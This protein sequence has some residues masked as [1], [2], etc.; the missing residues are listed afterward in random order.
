MPRSFHVNPQNVFTNHHAFSHRK[1]AKR[2]YVA[3]PLIAL[4]VSMSPA[5]MGANGTWNQ[6]AGGNWEL[7]TTGP[8]LGGVVANGSGAI[9][10]FTTQDITGDQTITLTTDAISVGQLKFQDATT[11]TNN[12]ILASNAPPLTLDNGA[13]QPIINILNQTTTIT[14]ALAGTNGVNLTGG[15]ATLVLNSNTYTRSSGFTT[16]INSTGGN[17]FNIVANANTAFGTGSIDVAS[18]TRYRILLNSGVTINNN[19]QLDSI[20]ST[21]GGNGALQTNGDVTATLTGTIT[22]NGSNTAGGGVVG[23]QEGTYSRTGNFLIFTGAL[24]AGA[25]ISGTQAKTVTGG[26]GNKPIVFR[27]GNVQLSGGGNLYRIEQ[28]AGAIQLGATNGAPTTAYIDLGGNSNGNPQNY[29]ILDLN[30]FN[31][32]LTGVTNFVNNGQSATVT[33]SSTTST[34]TLTLT[35]AAQSVGD[36]RDLV[37]TAGANGTGTNASLTDSSPA[38]PLNLTVN[39]AADGVQYMTTSASSYRGVT[40]LTSG[41]LAVSS[42]ANGGV[43]SSIGASSNAA[44]NLM[45]NG[46]T[47]RYVNTALQANETNQALG[48]ATTASTDRNFTIANGSNGTIDVASAA[49]T[50]TFTGGSAAT[51]GNLIVNGNPVAG[52]APQGGLGLGTLVLAGTNLHSGTTSVNSGT[53]LVNGSLAGGAVSVASGATLGGTGTIGGTVT[54]ASGGFVAPGDPAVASGIGTLTV[55]ALSLNSGADVVYQFGTGND[56]INV[57]SSG[58]LSLGSGSSIDVFDTSGNQY[59]TNGLY[60]LFNYSARWAAASEI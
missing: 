21:A 25:A 57:S 32:S 47:L 31:Q 45:F 3:L 54:P 8:W 22:F 53:L 52:S 26:T 36:L 56:L 18:G 12:W 60:T 51:T 33:N 27:A 39:G 6:T 2:L 58:G 55:N 10:D 24:N 50:V 59:T 30:G 11:A 14:A 4:V 19:I 9:A 23:A 28:R 7:A 29:S 46:G 41:V 34:A 16:V 17:Q 15:N 1:L 43:N 44:S 49:A 37:F 40:T 42:L 13:S 38:T 20:N 35:P 48:N 5:A